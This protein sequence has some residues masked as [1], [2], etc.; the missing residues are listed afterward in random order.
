MRYPFEKQF[1]VTQKFGQTHAAITGGVHT[2]LDIGAPAGTP[3]LAIATGTVIASG[4]ETAGGNFVRVDVGGLSVGYYHLSQ[5]NVAAGAVVNE[6]SV[7]GLVGSSGWATGPHLHLEIVRGG[8]AVDPQ[9]YISGQTSSPTPAPR[10]PPSDGVYVIQKNDTL[11]GLEERWN[12]PHGRLQELNPG[13]D[14]RALQIG[15]HIRTAPAAT[16]TPVST[17]QHYTIQPGDTFWGLENAWQLPHGRL[18]ELNP[19]QDARNLQIGQRIR[20]K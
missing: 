8:A 10:T 4:Y 7:I 17:E 12:L 2:G 6:G 16:A 13:Q 19:G 14:P 9:P 11:W 20:I 3:V 5:R 1:P 18:Q 15:Q